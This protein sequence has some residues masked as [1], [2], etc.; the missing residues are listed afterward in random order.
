MRR[1]IATAF[2]DEHTTGVGMAIVVE[3]QHIGTA[4][5]FGYAEF[6]DRVAAEDYA[7]AELMRLGES[8]ADAR[9]AA[10]LATNTPADASGRG[11]AVRIS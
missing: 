4:G 6:D 11:Y 1:C 9:A 2:D 7:T 8:A 5:F 3:L 10:K